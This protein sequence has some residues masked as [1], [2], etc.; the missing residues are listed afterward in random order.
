MF[1]GSTVIQARGSNKENA[2]AVV[3]KTGFM[4]SK[5]ALVRNI[6]YPK[7]LNFSFYM[8]AMRFMLFM[9]MLSLVAFCIALPFL[10]YKFHFPTITV[11]EDSLDLI[12][13]V[14]PAALPTCMT[15][16]IS[17]AVMRLKD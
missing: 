1:A 4:T 17:L 5:G 6:L 12:S 15:I 16:G 10:W 2:L 3:T 8:E 13:I 11:V 9:A 14:L 7:D